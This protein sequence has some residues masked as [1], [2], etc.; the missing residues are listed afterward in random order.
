[1]IILYGILENRPG[2]ADKH[3]SLQICADYSG[4]MAGYRDRCHLRSLVYLHLFSL[5]RNIIVGR[6]LPQA[7]PKIEVCVLVLLFIID[8]VYKVW[9]LLYNH[10]L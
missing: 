3:S 8:R 1:M 7:I 5:N 4:S 6:G 9:S 2:G 10:F